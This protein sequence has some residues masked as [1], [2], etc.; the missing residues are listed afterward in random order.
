ML[1]WRNVFTFPLIFNATLDTKLAHNNFGLVKKR[2]GEKIIDLPAKSCDYGGAIQNISSEMEFSSK[3]GGFLMNGEIT[4]MLRAWSDGNRDIA[5]NF[6]PLI[7]DELRLQ[8]HRYL[9]R[10]RKNHSLQTTGLVHEAYIRIIEQRHV[11]W[12][13]RAHFFGIAANMM[14]RILVNYAINRNRLKRGGAD[15]T[16]PLEEALSVAHDEN[17]VDLLALNEALTR[18]EEMDE[19]QA[20]IVELKFFSGLSIEETAEVLSISP[21][22]VKRDWVMAKTWL[23]AELSGGET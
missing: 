3:A 14:R 21:A 20:R 23:R 1:L 2:F 19:R 5:D 9:S 12:Q 18:L 11:D 15:E 8:A 4:Q 17:D 7:Y 6:M 10:E 13:N 22:T 16:L